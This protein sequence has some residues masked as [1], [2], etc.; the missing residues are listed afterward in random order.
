MVRSS[1]RNIVRLATFLSNIVYG[2]FGRGLVANVEGLVVEPDVA[3]HEVR[4]QDVA[5]FVVEGRV[6]RDPF[7]LHG[8]CFEA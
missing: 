1:G 5:G 4:E 6:D 8:N 2:L 7:L 3:A